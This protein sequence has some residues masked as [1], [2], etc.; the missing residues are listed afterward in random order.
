[1]LF[2][3]ILFSLTVFC[4]VEENQALVQQ[5]QNVFLECS[6]KKSDSRWES[7][8]VKHKSSLDANCKEWTALLPFSKFNPVHDTEFMIEGYISEVVHFPIFLRRTKRCKIVFWYFDKFVR[9]DVFMRLSVRMKDFEVVRSV[10]RPFSAKSY[11]EQVNAIRSEYEDSIK[12]D[13]SSMLV[14]LI[15]NLVQIVLACDR[16]I[17]ELFKKIFKGESPKVAYPPA[18]DFEVIRV[19]DPWITTSELPVLMISQ[20]EM[21]FLHPILIPSG[22]LILSIDE[23]TKT[24]K[25]APLLFYL[26]DWRNKLVTLVELLL[27]FSELEIAQQTKKREFE[28]PNKSLDS[29]LYNVFSKKFHKN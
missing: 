17:Y 15:K 4:S 14:A 23:S 13:A 29:A 12:V 2:A 10:P 16:D 27:V 3:L 5:I 9:R 22:S 11:E 21:G 6:Q 7:P 25:S 20:K 8:S 19:T 28:I 24:Q 26:P 18:S 1:M